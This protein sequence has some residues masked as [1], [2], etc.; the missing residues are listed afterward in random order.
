MGRAIEADARTHARTRR[1]GAGSEDSRGGAVS[2]AAM[3]RAQREQRIV[4]AAHLRAEVQEAVAVLDLGATQSERV[5]RRVVEAGLGRDRDLEAG[6]LDEAHL[7]R[8]EEAGWVG[9]RL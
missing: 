7:A 9:E 4:A 8:A 3:Q 6:L 5:R 2:Q 1:G